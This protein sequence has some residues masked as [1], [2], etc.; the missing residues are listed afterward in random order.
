[1]CTIDVKCFESFT[2][3]PNVLPTFTF[4]SRHFPTLGLEKA[5]H[6]HSPNVCKDLH[7][8]SCK[9][10]I[11]TMANIQA[12]PQCGICMDQLPIFGN[13]DTT[14]SLCATCVKEVFSR[15]LQDEAQYP[16]RLG[17]HT[18]L[19]LSDCRRFLDNEIITA[20]EHKELE[21]GTLPVN[22]VYCRCEVF[23]GS[24]VKSLPSSIKVTASCPNGCEKIWCMVCATEIEAADRLDDHD[25][26]AKLSERT[27]EQN[28]ELEGLE[29]G[30]D[31]QLCPTCGRRVQLAEA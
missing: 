14:N 29:R 16:A 17:P 2:Q 23:V 31:Y 1:M 5:H 28:L 10:D 24:L 18:L 12:Q 8:Q 22:R 15:A 13:Y 9:L 21:C 11:A 6:P 20:Y 27:R 26:S 4:D 30:K 19:K 3:P 7:P 25:C